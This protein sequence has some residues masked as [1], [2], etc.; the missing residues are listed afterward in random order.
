MGRILKRGQA[1]STALR[2]Q[3]K[4]LESFDSKKHFLT[5]NG[6]T[7]EITVIE[8]TGLHQLMHKFGCFKADTVM[9][10]FTE[11]GKGSQKAIVSQSTAY[12]NFLNKMRSSNGKVTKKATFIADAMLDPAKTKAKVASVLKS[13]ISK[14]AKL[15][16]EFSPRGDFTKEQVKRFDK[17]CEN[18]ALKLVERGIYKTDEQLKKC[19]SGLVEKARIARRNHLVLAKQYNVTP[20]NLKNMAFEIYSNFRHSLPK[21]LEQYL[22]ECYVPRI[23]TPESTRRSRGTCL[24][25]YSKRRSLEN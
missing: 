11:L 1:Q 5:V 22:D 15:S 24:E 23:I 21:Y 9:K 20:E 10:R 14:Q 7:K 12:R 17:A 4:K 6:K 18:I 19:A 13:E 3:L 2:D 25:S 8:K 16:K